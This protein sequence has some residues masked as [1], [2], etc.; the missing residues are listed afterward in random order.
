MKK[1]NIIIAVVATIFGSMSCTNEEYLLYDGDRINMLSFAQDSVEFNYGF[2]EDSDVDIEVPLYFMGL[3]VDSNTKVDVRVKDSGEA[4]EDA[5]FAVADTYLMKDSTT[6]F[7]PIDIDKAKLIGNKEYVVI[8]EIVSSNSFEATNKQTCKVKFG[9]M[10]MDQPI[11][12]DI[13]ILGIYT[14]EKHILFVH[15]FWECE[16]LSPYMFNE[17]VVTDGFGRNLD[18]VPTSPGYS[19]DGLLSQYYY[20]DFFSAYIYPVMYDKYI[21]TGDENYAMPDPNL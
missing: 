9:N 11:W 14:Q 18:V 21:E 20:K 17:I 13:D 3:T 4:A 12:W 6:L 7:V 16:A 1:I 10:D 2:I 15:T 8:L 5:E 19:P